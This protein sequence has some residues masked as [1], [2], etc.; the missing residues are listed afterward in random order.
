MED[1]VRTIQN[2]QGYERPTERRQQILT[3][4]LQIF[5]VKG[6]Q[7]SIAEI[8]ALA[9]VNESTIYRYFKNKEDL[10]FYVGAE[11]LRRKT[12]D[13]KIQLAG[14]REPLSQLSKLIWCLRLYNEGSNAP[15]VKFDLF[16][17]RGKARYH[18]HEAFKYSIH[19]ALT[20]E[21]ILREGIRQGVF[22]D[23]MNIPIARDTICGFLEMENIQF[24]VNHRPETGPDE[25]DDIMDLITH[26]L[27]G[28]TGNQGK[29]QGK[30]Q[31]ILD[32][33]EALFAE[34]GYQNATTIGI[35][36]SAGVAE[37][38]LYE[39]FKGK[40]DILFTD[41]HSRLENH[42]KPLSNNPE[43]EMPVERFR[44]FIRNFF[45]LFLSRQ[46]FANTF[47]SEGI[48]NIR[49]YQTRAYETFR[50][51]LENID[52]IL[53][54]GEKKGVFRP[55]IK[56]QI[57]KN[58]LLGIFCASTNRVLYLEDC[59]SWNVLEEIDATVTLLE[60]AVIQPQGEG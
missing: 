49:F 6:E 8:A 31:V 17:C 43:S 10:M 25:F 15:Y 29:P 3:A 7:S 47:I 41:L 57:I 54:E 27:D 59:R 2:D 55:G 12:E 35:A 30:Q 19:F 42:L 33:A 32:A 24:Y 28:R 5:P 13:L 53:Q 21:E 50:A 56:P 22:W 46:S 45:I 36:R 38:T 58:L 14:I 26:M 9:G 16:E 51:Y 1:S 48:Y 60:R 39:Y 18:K 20:V 23:C 34:F 4:A 44:G 37:A 40:E 11:C 52:L